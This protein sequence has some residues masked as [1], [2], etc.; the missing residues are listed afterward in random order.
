MIIIAWD[1]D[2]LICEDY[3]G[4][5]GEER[6]T[7]WMKTARPLFIPSNAIEIIITG[8]QE[9]FRRITEDWINSHHI[10]CRKLVMRPDNNTIDIIG[11]KVG[12]INRERV[13]IYLESDYGQACKIRSRT[14]ALILN[15]CMKVSQ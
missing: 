9:R 15:S 12:A 4:H 7:K 2:G 8:R 3:P 6:Y 1:L 13:D 14:Q 11:F 10:Q 5:M